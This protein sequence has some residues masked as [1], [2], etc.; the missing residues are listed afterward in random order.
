MK[1][2]VLLCATFLAAVFF[3][4]ITSAQAGTAKVKFGAYSAGE[5]CSGTGICQ[6]SA[7]DGADVEFDYFETKDSSGGNMSILTMLF[8]Y[9]DAKRNGFLGDSFGGVYTFTKGYR[10]NHTGDGRTGVPSTYSIPDDYDGKYTAKDNNGM[11]KLTVTQYS[12]PSK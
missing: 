6:T 3:I 5:G 10:F 9:E 4:N 12:T 7:I 8:N 11:I 1:K 2:Q